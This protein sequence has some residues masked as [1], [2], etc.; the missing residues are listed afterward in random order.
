MS[1]CL[2]GPDVRLNGQWNLSSA[3]FPYV[4]LQLGKFNAWR[5]G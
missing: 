2:G 5:Q 1:I 3:H 4:A